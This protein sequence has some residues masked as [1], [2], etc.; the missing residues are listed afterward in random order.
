[1]NAGI[2]IVFAIAAVAALVLFGLVALIVGIAALARIKRSDGKLRGRGFAIAAIVLGAMMIVGLPVVGALT[3]PLLFYARREGRM[4]EMKRR[5]ADEARRAFEKKRATEAASASATT[6]RGPFLIVDVGAAGVYSVRGSKFGEAG[7][8]KR[9]AEEVA[10]TRKSSDGLS[11]L[12]VLI[13]GR[14][15]TPYSAA[16]KV[17]LLCARAKV[18]RVYLAEEGGVPVP[19]PLARDKGLV[20]LVA[21][22]G[23]AKELL[24]KVGVVEGKPQFKIGSWTTDDAGQLLARLKT[25]KQVGDMPVIIDGT[26]GCP[27]RYV[28]QAL[29]ACAK[30]EFTNVQFRAPALKGVGD[31]ADPPKRDIFKKEGVRVESEKGVEEPVEKSK[32]Q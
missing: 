2:V 27:F 11:E 26:T 19:T 16:Q 21:E 24:I 7:L 3:M 32:S 28:M 14:K 9:I 17:M 25:L 30:A 1:L 31:A 10:R 23:E 20:P 29:D 4:E 22:A 15:G 13:R 18:W 6:I 8:R 12:G 5:D